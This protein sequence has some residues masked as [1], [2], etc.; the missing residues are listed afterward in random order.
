VDWREY[1]VV[2]SV[3]SQGSCGACWAITA[4]ETIESAYA[5]KTGTLMDLCETEVIVCEED[6]EMCN[7][8]WPQNAYDFNMEQGGLLAESSW[9]YDG[10][11]L[12]ALTAASDGGDDD[13][14]K[15][16][17]RCITVFCFHSNCCSLTRSAIVPFYYI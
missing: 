1:G 17:N 3:H 13:K 2:S 6:C 8:G 12:S 14:Y 4:V 7:G 10:D 9:S 11:F 5:L 16:D 15:Y